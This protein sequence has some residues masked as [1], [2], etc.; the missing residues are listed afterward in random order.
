M[1]RL[2]LIFM[3]T[4][5]MLS[6]CGCANDTATPT[7]GSVATSSA[8]DSL[9]ASKAESASSAAEEQA[10]TLTVPAEHDAVAKAVHD[11]LDAA[12]KYDLNDFSTTESSILLSGKAPIPLTVK[13]SASDSFKAD[14]VTVYLSENPDMSNAVE[15]DATS[16]K[17]L[18]IAYIKTGI[19]YYVRAVATASDKTVQ[20][21]IYPVKIAAGPRLFSTSGCGISNLRDLGGWTTT[22]GKLVKQGLIFRSAK[23]DSITELGKSLLTQTLGIKTEID[24]RWD[25]EIDNTAL[26]KASPIGED[27]KRVRALVN[28]YAEA[29]GSK[30][31]TE[32]MKVFADWSNYPVLFHCAGGA[33]RTGTI[34]FLLN[35]LLGVDEYSLIADYELTNDRPRS[36]GINGANGGFYGLWQAVQKYDGKTMQE[37]CYNLL[38][39]HKLTEMEISN[40]YNIMLTNSAVFDASSLGAQS[41]S[42][43]KLTYKLIMRD[44]KSVKKVEIGGKSA[45]FT[46]SGDTLTVNANGNGSGIITLDDGAT[47][48]FKF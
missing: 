17:S 8:A 18:S 7:T 15:Y 32:A 12:K 42:D 2:V 21:E 28:N 11:F 23:Y 41:P 4:F 34:A 24:F 26:R 30:T 13:W 3:V 37:K 25:H 44:S 43:N 29:I 33:D 20:T 35:G 48:R 38:L 47:L 19:T 14:K 9:S 45:Q 36:Y 6:A 5:I 31:T 22:D 39:D 10:F 40:I 46:L 1:K 27:I 16:S